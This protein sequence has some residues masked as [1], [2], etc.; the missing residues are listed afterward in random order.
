MSSVLIGK[1]NESGIHISE[2]IFLGYV[3]GMR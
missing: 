3:E 2:I 1:A